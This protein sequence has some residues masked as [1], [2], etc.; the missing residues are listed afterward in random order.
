MPA[1]TN[2]PHVTN[3]ARAIRLAANHRI[4]FIRQIQNPQDA[5]EQYV[6]ASRSSFADRSAWWGILGLVIGLAISTPT[7]MAATKNSK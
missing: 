1:T 6:T 7:V 5:I 3:S 2:A 4:P